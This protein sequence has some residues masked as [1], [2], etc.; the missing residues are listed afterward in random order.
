MS[1]SF[2]NSINI[3]CI[4]CLFHKKGISQLKNFK[5]ILNNKH[6]INKKSGKFYDILVVK[7]FQ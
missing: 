6:L 7:A 3:F 5:T 4:N 2:G 1:A